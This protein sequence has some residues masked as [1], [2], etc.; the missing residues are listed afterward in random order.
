MQSHFTEGEAEALYCQVTCPT[1]QQW[2]WVTPSLPWAGPPCA[3]PSGSFWALT[4]RS[5]GERGLRE[6]GSWFMAVC[7]VSLLRL[8]EEAAV[9]K[10]QPSSSSC[11]A[12]D[13][14][15]HEAGP[16]CPICKAAACRGHRFLWLVI[17]DALGI[18]PGSGHTPGSVV[19]EKSLPERASL[20]PSL[21]LWAQHSADSRC[22]RQLSGPGVGCGSGHVDR[23]A[24]ETCLSKQSARLR[25]PE[26]LCSP[27]F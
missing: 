12:T 22:S 25:A 1:G 9:A 21:R 27:D 6:A 2:D 4:P 5:R 11:S 23:M 16:Q 24:L 17:R 8:G 3:V 18:V 26:P 19:G 10:A 13:Q 14:L 7:C 20:A 15:E